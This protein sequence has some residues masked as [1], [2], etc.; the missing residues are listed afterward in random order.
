M[1]ISESI[2]QA[3]D[4]IRT[5]KLRTFLTLL[6][7]AMGVFALIVA[8]TI[9]TS[10]EKAVTKQLED[11]G[12]TT[13]WIQRTP[14]IQTGNTW[15]KYRKRKPITYNE[16][17]ELKK[18]T[19]STNIIS[20]HSYTFGMTITAGNLSTDPDVYLA[21]A[22]NNFFITNAIDVDY[23]RIFTEEDINFNR[24]VAI[25][26]NDVLVKIFPNVNPIGKEITIKNQKYTV[27]GVLKSRGAV[28]GQSKDNMVIIPLTNFLKYFASPWEESLTISVRAKS[29][30]ALEE[31]I[32]EVIGNLRVIRNVKPWEEN[33]FEVETNETIS[34]QFGSFVN[35]LSIFGFI[36]GGFALI[37]AGVGIM[38]IMLVAVKER[39]REIGIR[40]A[41]GAKRRWILWQ[42][43]L[44]AISLC[45]V[46]GVVGII[47]GTLGGYLLGNLIK[48]PMHFPISWIILSVIVC[49]ILGISF[50]AY[51]AY[52]AAN[53]DPIEALRY[54]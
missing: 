22:E 44:E 19:T 30:E 18:M 4:A 6:S 3:F 15:R 32:D 12:E 36:S 38:N 29:K 25:I 24:N 7:I 10:F 39:T 41:V 37:A 17:K 28:L 35:F 53:L 26:G 47:F 9:I 5:N 33:T 54:E 14:A 20:A 31:T 8:G 42:F 11:V 40:K 45:Q 51:P 52:R 1:N 49:T 16:F 43:I 34:Q 21:G 48:L 2:F 50:G 13:F 23:G 27:I 46:G